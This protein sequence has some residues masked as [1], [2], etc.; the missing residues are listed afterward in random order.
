MTREKK[1]DFCEGESEEHCGCM[2][3]DTCTS[4]AVKLI[5]RYGKTVSGGILKHYDAYNKNASL[6]NETTLCKA[7]WEH[8]NP[9]LRAFIQSYQKYISKADVHELLDQLIVSNDSASS[10]DT[11]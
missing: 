10:E 8:I 3:L 11:C 7:V 5:Q 1:C 2:W 4:L 9:K 6:E